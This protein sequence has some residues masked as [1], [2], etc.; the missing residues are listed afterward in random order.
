MAAPFI[1]VAA[2]FGGFTALAYAARYAA[3]LA[4]LVLVDSSHP[5]QGAAALAAIPDSE[6]HAPAVGKFRA[7]LQGF[8]PVW[9]ESCEEIARIRTLGDVPMMVLAAGD[10]DVPVE[11]SEGTR[12]ALTQSWHDLQRQLANLSTRAEL[13]IVPRAGHNIVATAP[14]VII[15]AVSERQRTRSFSGK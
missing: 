4:G 9:T 14:E 11:L 6:G 10:P 13:R 1:L 2:S 7:Y 8:G 15:A 3:T 5:G 12:T